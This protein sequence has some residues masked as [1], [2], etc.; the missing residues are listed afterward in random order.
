M[1]R[2][3]R[4]E[5]AGAIHH[6]FARGTEKLPIFRDDADCQVYLAILR[7]VLHVY[8]WNCLGYCLMTNHPHLLL[9]TPEPNLG[10]GMKRLHGAYAQFFNLRYERSGHLF[11]GR[12]KNVPITDEVQLLVAIRYVANNPVEAG[13]CATPSDWRRSSCAATLGLRGDPWI[14]AEHVLRFLELY[15][16]DP[17][18]Y[19]AGLIDAAGPEADGGRLRLAA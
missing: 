9:E 16:P 18:A 11:A 2:S 13:L 15:S 12:F 10:E 17:L 1:P 5:A 8:G 4:G 14:D 19:Y 6:V 3:P 7:G